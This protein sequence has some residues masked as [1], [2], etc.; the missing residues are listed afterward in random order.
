MADQ[1]LKRQMRYSDDEL[2]HIRALFADDGGEKSLMIIRKFLFQG[3]MS[4]L[5]LEFLSNFRQ[6]PESLRLLRKTLLPEIDPESPL[7]QFADTLIGVSTADRHTEIV[8]LEIQMKTIL[9]KY[10]NDQLRQIEGE[11]VKVSQ[12]INLKSL[13]SFNR[14]T[15]QEAH[16]DLGARN[17]I[18]AH[19][20][21]MMLQ[22]KILA[23]QKKETPDEKVTREKKDSLK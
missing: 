15:P 21:S 5:E 23:N 11:P 2:G 4:N 12:L 13:A 10:I 8:W 9:E 6:N 19:I 7:F 14:K 3:T 18:L 17:M 22:L 1:E 16:I 20:D